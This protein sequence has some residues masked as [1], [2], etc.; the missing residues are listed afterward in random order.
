MIKCIKCKIKLDVKE[1]QI[2][3]EANEFDHADP[4]CDDCFNMEE[5]LDPHE[6]QYSDADLGL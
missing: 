3:K 2:W 6:D 5:N 4:V 1:E